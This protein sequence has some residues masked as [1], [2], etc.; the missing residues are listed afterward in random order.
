MIQMMY[1]IDPTIQLADPTFDEID[2]SI[3]ERIEAYLN[4]CDIYHVQPDSSILISLMTGWNVIKPSKNFKEG[5]LLPL[6]N[7]LCDDENVT[8]LDLSHTCTSG[9]GDSNMRI[10]RGILS[11]NSTITHL[12][13][14]KCNVSD[15]GVAELSLGL[16]NNSSLKFA[17]SPSHS[18]L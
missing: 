18:N 3:Q 13:L 17:N 14:S 1:G 8:H 9:N 10:L 16:K 12:D 7:V 15:Y 5:H 4:N 2:S 6:S 11:K